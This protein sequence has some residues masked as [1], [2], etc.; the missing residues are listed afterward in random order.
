MDS[1]SA[2][3]YAPA[4]LTG[5]LARRPSADVAFQ[6]AVLYTDIVGSS[7]LSRAYVERGVEALG[8]ALNAYFADLFTVVEAYGGEVLR[9]DGDAMFAL[10]RAA[11]AAPLEPAL[12][13]AA[14]AAQT[15]RP[16]V[17]ECCGDLAA[18][19]HRL[20]L[21]CGLLRAELVDSEGGRAF[22]MVSGAPLDALSGPLARGA[23]GEVLAS[24]TVRAALGDVAAFAPAGPGLWRLLASPALKGATTKAAPASV[25]VMAAALAPRLL[26]AAA[27]A[28]LEGGVPQ[29]I[30]EFRRISCI[31]IGLAVYDAGALALAQAALTPLRAGLWD[32]TVLDKG[33]LLTVVFGLPPFTRE[34]GAQWAVEAA[35]KIAEALAG[36]GAAPAIGIATGDALA[37]DVG[38]KRRRS[39]FLLGEV[40]MRATRLMQAAS[41]EILCDEETARVSASRFGFV[42]PLD[43]VIKRGEPP[44]P[45]FRLTSITAPQNSAE[46]DDYADPAI[47]RSA[48]AARIAA[49]LATPTDAVAPHALLIEAEPGFRKSHLLRDAVAAALRCGSQVCAVVCNPIDAAT[50]HYAFRSV[51]PW[52]VGAGAEEGDVTMA[53][54]W[55]VGG[56][57]QRRL[58][59]AVAA[60]LGRHPLAGQDVILDAAVAIAGAGAEAEGL[61]A[62]ARADA[63]EEVVVALAR[64]RA[65]AGPLVIAVDDVQWLDAASARLLEAMLDRVAGCRIIAACR[66]PEHGARTPTG[67]TL[68]SERLQ[69]TPLGREHIPALVGRLLNVDEPPER[70]C[71]LVERRAEGV[72][73]YAEQFVY[74]LRQRGLISVANRRCTLRADDIA[75]L[76]PPRSIR[77]LINGRVDLL[78]T[79]DQI[80]LKTASV[81]G[82]QAPRD[83]LAAICPVPIDA[84]DLARAA[85]ALTDAGFLAETRGAWVFR[86]RVIRDSVYGM[87]TDGQRRPLHGAV[88]A[89][90]RAKHDGD[91]SPVLGDLA[92][93]CEGAG[94]YVGAVRY[95]EQ[96][97]EQALS[98]YANAD[99]LARLER[100]RRLLDTHAASE[101]A[102]AVDENS[103]RIAYL[104]GKAC[105]GLSRFAEAAEHF[106][107]FARERGHPLPLSRRE[108][109]ARL[110]VEIAAQGL[111]RLGALGIA[112]HPK[113]AERAK[114]QSRVYTA[115][116]EHAYFGNDS[117]RLLYFSVLALNRAERAKAAPETAEGLGAI[118]IGLG[119]AG[120]HRLARFYCEKAVAVAERGGDP[121]LIGF[122]HL[123][124][125][126]YSI[127]AADW[128]AVDRHGAAGQAACAR[129]GDRSRMQSCDLLMSFGMMWRGRGAE[130]DAGFS[131]Y[132]ANAEEIGNVPVR[133]WFRVGRVV[134]ELTARRITPATLERLGI[135][136]EPRL[137]PA[138]RLMCR[139]MRAGVLLR[140]GRGEAAL[141]EAGETLDAMRAAPVTL[142]IAL[143]SITA[144]A[145]THLDALARSKGLGPALDRRAEDACSVAARF[146]R[147][148]VAGRS[149]A[150]WLQGRLATLRGR[151]RHAA[152]LFTRPRSRHRSSRTRRRA[153]GAVAVRGTGAGGQ[154]TRAPDTVATQRAG[155]FGCGPCCVRFCGHCADTHLPDH[156]LCFVRGR[157]MLTSLRNLVPLA[158]LEP[159]RCC[160][161][162]ILS[163]PRLPIPPQG[164]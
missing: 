76:A 130:A 7:G 66:P 94:D 49:F 53:V 81:V 82:R 132:G 80:L 17:V 96:A 57:G 145:L 40:M 6:G 127:N 71:E 20:A 136:E 121:A 114:V 158:G 69:L 106:G 162:Q 110:P 54:A 16:V 133:A 51:L 12:R 83:T 23:A 86:H 117:L 119:A 90:L 68:R 157:K 37:G 39:E 65:A 18:V 5:A 99:A 105:Q 19:P 15:L 36:A 13:A 102:G 147:Q 142:G 63:A 126:V 131:A 113:D 14:A 154:A 109:L 161:Q 24:D 115:F 160:Q 124:A 25:D 159:A 75:A 140:L 125:T 3:I 137:A 61:G 77:E 43:V 35:R 52:L 92:E 151:P 62:K 122:T 116:A 78:S 150:L 103:A 108:I 70:L 118:A 139:G 47:G 28:R 2:L 72:P 42:A 31:Q 10:W 91:L 79:R 141:A 148:V 112:R 163:L 149:R 29:W 34:N 152:R 56:E 59:A 89:L 44:I 9:L 1:A 101:A 143:D 98:R 156:N 67:L 120:W 48:E 30:A 87:L 97:A 84:G 107:R 138:E 74:E 11:P 128:V 22:I 153:P 58:R 64:A 46:I 100:V 21:S 88:A 129:A 146:G 144:V 27:R 60:A 26:S 95:G 85:G 104:S 33:A 164:H 8:A 73:L 4:S 135:A 32:L 155:A 38:T 93:H 55:H 111:R 41:A 123:L 45:A 134:R 50:P